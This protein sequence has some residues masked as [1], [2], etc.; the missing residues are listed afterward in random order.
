MSTGRTP[1]ATDFKMYKVGRCI[2]GTL[3]RKSNVCG[4]KTLSY[5]RYDPLVKY[6]C[7]LQARKRIKLRAMHSIPC[8]EIGYFF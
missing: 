1:K 2:R 8:A 5:S 6:F 7:E 4:G 3:D